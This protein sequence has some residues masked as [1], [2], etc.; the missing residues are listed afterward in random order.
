[1]GAVVQLGRA[2]QDAFDAAGV[3]H[4]DAGA[5]GQHRAW[6]GHAPVKA[7]AGSFLSTGDGGTDQHGIS[8]AG[9]ALADV[10]TGDDA[11]VGNDRHVATAFLFVVGPGGST[12]GHCG[13]CLLYTSP[14]PRDMRRS[15]MPSSA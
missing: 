7:P 4:I 6:G 12:V 3:A 8:A 9:D 1:M 15:R 10:T 5:A 13:G 2:A 14:S 11:T